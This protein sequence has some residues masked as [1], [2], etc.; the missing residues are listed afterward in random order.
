VLLGGYVGRRLYT[1]LE[2]LISRIPGFKQVYPHVK[3]LVDLI[4]G[5][6]PTSFKRAV[7]VQ[8]PRRG[9][10][11]VGLLTGSS[12]KDIHQAAETECVSIFIPSTPTPFTGFTITVPRNEIIDLPIT[13]DEAI[14]FFITGG[15]LV[16]EKQLPTGVPPPPAPELPGAAPAPSGRVAE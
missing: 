3:Q 11:T 15:A 16:P 9:I 4:M 12:M 6:R 8:Y 2:S 10:W 1:R 7:L 14:R 13:I 5:D